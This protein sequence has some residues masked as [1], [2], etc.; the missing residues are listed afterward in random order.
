MKIQSPICNAYGHPINNNVL[1]NYL[2]MNS[3]SQVCYT[4]G[5][6]VN[7]LVSGLGDIQSKEF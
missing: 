6:R 5:Q 3:N 1:R 7:I 2:A 4:D